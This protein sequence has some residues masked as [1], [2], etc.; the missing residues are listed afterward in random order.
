MFLVSAANINNILI[1]SMLKE[2]FSPQVDKIKNDNVA[3]AIFSC[4]IA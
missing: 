1:R 2:Y 3:L 4:F